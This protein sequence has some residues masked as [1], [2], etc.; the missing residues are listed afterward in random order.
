[1]RWLLLCGVVAFACCGQIMTAEWS[2]DRNGSY[3]D[4]SHQTKGCEQGR[5]LI[6]KTVIEG[7]FEALL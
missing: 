3:P 6:R 4:Y 2:K 7:E 5:A 1:M